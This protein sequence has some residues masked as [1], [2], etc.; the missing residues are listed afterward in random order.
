[1]GRTNSSLR[2][3]FIV[4]G[5]VVLL[6]AMSFLGPMF[7]FWFGLGKRMGF[8]FMAMMVVLY[9]FIKMRKTPGRETRR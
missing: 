8:I 1:M 2:G 5:I 6:M 9:F 7:K 4:I 3:W